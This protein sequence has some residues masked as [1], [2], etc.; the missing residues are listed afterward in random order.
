[1]IHEAA[2]ALDALGIPYRC[3]AGGFALKIVTR[4]RQIPVRIRVVGDRITLYAPLGAM[5]DAADAAIYCNKRNRTLG[6][7]CLVAKEDGSIFLKQTAYLHDALLAKECMERALERQRALL[8]M[9]PQNGSIR[10]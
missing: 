9:L 3:V 2:A 8:D 6:D 10:P 4:G 5:Q 7:G 1:M